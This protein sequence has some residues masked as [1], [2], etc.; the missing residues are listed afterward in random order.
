[1]ASARPKR[2]GLKQL[3]VE[4]KDKLYLN[5]FRARGKTISIRTGKM[6]AFELEPLLC[7]ISVVFVRCS[8]FKYGEIKAALDPAFD[9]RAETNFRITIHI[10]LYIA[11]FAIN[12]YALSIRRKY[13]TGNKGPG[14]RP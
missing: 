12:C 11:S 6:R 8:T 9:R 3:S 10:G 1:M 4:F 7:M 5:N 2:A 13:E 14:N